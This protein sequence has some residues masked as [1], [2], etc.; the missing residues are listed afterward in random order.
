[1]QHGSSE[2]ETSSEK[3]RGAQERCGEEADRQEDRRGKAQTSC[4]EEEE[5]AGEGAG[6]TVPRACP[7]RQPSAARKRAYPQAFQIFSALTAH[8]L[9]VGC[10]LGSARPGFFLRSSPRLLIPA[11]GTETL[12]GDQGPKRANGRGEQALIYTP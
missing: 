8:P 12:A 5:V 4:E 7:S 11:C 3:A 9:S 1:M 2:E 10:R 6:A